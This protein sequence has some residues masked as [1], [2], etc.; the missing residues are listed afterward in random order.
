MCS[1]PHPLLQPEL[2]AHYRFVLLLHQSSAA[3][4]ARESCQPLAAGQVVGAAQP[5]LVLSLPTQPQ[6][7][8]HTMGHPQAGRDV[9]AELGASSAPAQVLGP[10]GSRRGGYKGST[11]EN[12]MVEGS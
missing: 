12:A 11:A 9:A 2:T 3:G 4:R 5:D 7:L 10:H 6:A 1:G 8:Q